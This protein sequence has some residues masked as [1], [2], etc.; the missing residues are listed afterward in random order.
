MATA[1][2]LG[3]LTAIVAALLT[4]VTGVV[5]AAVIAAGMLVSGA[6]VGYLSGALSSPTIASVMQDSTLESFEELTQAG[7]F[8]E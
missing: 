7:R 6:A 3:F 2:G 1:A 8:A 4:S 5:M